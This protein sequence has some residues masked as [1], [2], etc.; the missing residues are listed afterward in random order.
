MQSCTFGPFE[1]DS[2]DECLRHG[3]RAIH[4][5]PRA[6]AVLRYL[7]ER[8]G[9]LVTKKELLDRIWSDAIVGDAVLKVCVLEI[10]K[11]LDDKA[12]EPR[13]VQ[14]VHRRGYRFIAELQLRD[15]PALCAHG[16]PRCAP[17]APPPPDHAF[18]GREAELGMLTEAL[19]A[20]ETGVRSVV[21][22]RSRGGLRQDNSGRATARRRPKLVAPTRRSAAA[23]LP[24]APR[25][26]TIRSSKRS[27]GSAAAPRPTSIVDALRQIAPT[28]LLQMP[29]LISGDERAELDAP[30]PRRH[31]NAHAAGVRRGGRGDHQR[32]SARLGPRGSALRR[33]VERRL[34]AVPGA[35]R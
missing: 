16:E 33:C 34:A 9:K 24:A 35:A 29:W 8:A 13:Y 10:R 31:R 5:T 15:A 1:L 14:T 21:F 3:D 19:A 11:A 25:L 7:V 26:R 18:V 30:G 2:A 22:R 20:A 27:A 6:F 32:C 17:T 12:K 23:S 4:L 28:W